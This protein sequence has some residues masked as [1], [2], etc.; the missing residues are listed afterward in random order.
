LITDIHKNYNIYIGANPTA[1]INTGGIPVLCTPGSVT[2]AIL[3]GGQNSPNTI[4]TFQINDGSPAV[5][6]AHPPPAT[7]THNFTVTSCG[8][9]SIINSSAFPNS[10]QASITAS[11]LCGTSSGAFGP[12]NIQSPPDANFTRTPSNASICKGTTVLFTNTTTGGNNI[13]NAPNYPCTD[14][15]KKYWTITG[16]SGNIPVT[17]GGVLIANAFISAT[18][19][20]GYNNNLPNNSGAWIPSASNQLNITFNT[21]GIYTITLYTG[22]NSC[23]IS[24]ESQTICVNPEVIADFALSSPTGCVT[25]SVQLDNLSSL[26]GCSNANIYNWQVTHANPDDCPDASVPGWSFTSGDASSFEPEITFTTPGIYTI[27]LTTSL[28]DPVDGALCQ[29][30]VKTETITIKGKPQTSLSALTICEDDVIS[31][32]PIVFNCYAT[33]PVTYLWDFGNDPSITVSNLTA[34]NPTITFLQAGVYSYSLTLSNECGDNLYTNTVTVNPAVQMTA[35]GPVAGCLN[36]SIQLNGSISGGTTAGIWTAS[37]MGSFSP[38]NTALSPTYTPPVNFIGTIVFTLTSADP[39]GPCPSETTFFSV[40]F[41]DQ[42]TV[43]AGNYNSVCQNGTLQLNGVIG[44]AASSATW[45]S[46]NGGVF[47]DLNS[48]TSTYTPPSGFTE[49]IILTLTT[50]D[51]NGPC[52]S[53]TDTTTLTIVPSHSIATQPTD[54]QSICV[55]GNSNALSVAYTGGVGTAAYQWFSNTTNSNSGG[56]SISGATNDSYTPASFTT[57]GSF[58][59]YAVVSLSGSG[60]GQATSDVAEV[61]V[62]PD[63]I[64]DTQPLSTQT[65][66]LNSSPDNLT[67]TVSGGI[68]TFNYQWFQNTTNTNTGGTLIPGATNA[69]FTPNTSSVGTAYYYCMITQSGIGCNVTSATAAVII[70][71]APTVTT[72]PLPS[73][74]CEGGAPALLSIDFANGT[75]TVSFQW[76]SNNANSTSGG[77]LIPGAINASF[78]PPATTVGTTY[79]YCEITFSSGG[80]TSILS[81]TAEVIINPVPVLSDANAILCSG[82]QYLFNST[83]ANDILPVGLQYTWRLLSMTPAGTVTGSVNSVGPQN[84]FVQQLTNTSTKLLQLRVFAQAIHSF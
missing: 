9:T 40:V 50:N 56:T 83:N 26:P 64:V 29:P 1:I 79:Y 73:T 20:F 37:V 59:F 58:Y 31:L 47:S 12:I 36:T 68:G 60:C 71:P 4:Y 5:V 16:P 38:N 32:V 61:I 45:T 66:C 11:N 42:A 27:Q 54:T 39:S 63:P 75:G 53:A 67:V 70:V 10:F 78:A 49:T 33:D 41:N 22:S 18:E 81:N 57:A 52:E 35:T 65:L 15:Y 69:S 14:T 24:S 55:G 34:A 46:N 19:N 30:D 3:V 6:F 43:D 28:Q 74:V 51:P 17:S 44:G 2:Y 82:E 72:Q 25:T 7:Y 62:L 21:A 77:T 48:L 8:V 23:G 80:C 76:F 84:Q 13:G